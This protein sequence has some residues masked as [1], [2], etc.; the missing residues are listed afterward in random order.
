MVMKSKILRTACAWYLRIGGKAVAGYETTCAYSCSVFGIVMPQSYSIIHS[1]PRAHPDAV[2]EPIKRSTKWS[3]HRKYII[4]LMPLDQFHSSKARS[5]LHDYFT[6]CRLNFTVSNYFCNED[7]NHYSWTVHVPSCSISG[8]HSRKSTVEN[9]TKSP[10]LKRAC[11]R[12]C[13]IKQN[14]SV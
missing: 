2:M 13:S 12:S 8:I 4:L 7:I 5:P 9:W 6:V 10:N 14:S 1:E 11:G 3:D